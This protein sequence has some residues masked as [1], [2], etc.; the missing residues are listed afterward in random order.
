MEWSC[1]L[2]VNK[3]KHELNNKY[4]KFHAVLLIIGIMQV[5]VGD[6]VVPGNSVAEAE[7]LAKQSKKV[8]LGS[9]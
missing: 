9:G 8:I 4:H 5:V 2:T 6:V 1:S 3:H 7:E